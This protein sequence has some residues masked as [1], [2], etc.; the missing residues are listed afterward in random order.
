MATESTTSIPASCSPLV[1]YDG[2]QEVW[3]QTPAEADTTSFASEAEGGNIMGTL[4]TPLELL[5]LDHLTLGQH[6]E[7]GIAKRTISEFCFEKES[8]VNQVLERMPPPLK[9]R[10][11]LCKPMLNQRL[12]T[13]SPLYQTLIKVGV[14]IYQFTI[15]MRT[16]PSQDG[17]TRCLSRSGV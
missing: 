15:R 7:Q 14:N 13:R 1:R 17:R 16:I 6:R 2:V 3:R 12:D 11:E 5:S 8:W 10:M 4:P 9:A